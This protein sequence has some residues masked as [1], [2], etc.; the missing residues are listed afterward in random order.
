MVR[1]RVLEIEMLRRVLDLIW[2]KEQR[3]GEFG[4]HTLKAIQ[5]IMFITPNR[6]RWVQ[7]V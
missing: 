7:H 5:C 3:D 2:R 1:C 4:I 6:M